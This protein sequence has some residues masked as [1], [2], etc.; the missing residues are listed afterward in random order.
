V[1]FRGVIE[2]IEDGSAAA[3]GWV[4]GRRPAIRDDQLVIGHAT[5]AWHAAR[6]EAI[7]MSNEDMSF[8]RLAAD[9]MRALLLANRQRSGPQGRTGCGTLDDFGYCTNVSH[10]VACAAS[11]SSAASKATFKIPGSR[12]ADEAWRAVAAERESLAAITRSP[13]A[14]AAHAEREAKAREREAERARK[15]AL[16]ETGANW[17]TTGRGAGWLNTGTG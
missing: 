2:L 3:D 13:A 11:M 9:E 16:R 14:A 6:Q 10:S 15:A 4:R 5:A 7:G 17:A 1:T 8:A 12:E